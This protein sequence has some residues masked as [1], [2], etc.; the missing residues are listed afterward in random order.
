MGSPDLCLRPPSG[1]GLKKAAVM[2]AVRKKMQSMKFDI[3]ALYQKNAEYEDDIKSS[4]A[5]SD[6]Y[7]VQ[8]RDVGKKVQKLETAFEEIQEK[9][10]ASAAKMDEAEKEFKDKD[11]DVN[12]AARRV[13]LMEGEAT[14]SV[15]KLATTVMKLAL[16]SKE[17]DN[18]IKGARHWESKTMNNNLK[19][20]RRIASDNE[21]KYDNLARSLAM[22]E[23]ELKR[24][25][26]R[27]KLAEGRVVKI[28]EELSTIGDN[29]KQ[30]EISEE[31]ARRRE[32]KYQDQIKQINIKL[33]ESDSRSEYAEMNITKL[34]LR[35]DEL[36]DEIIRE[37]LKINA[38]SG[39]L[40]ATF[41]EMLNKY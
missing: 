27:V 40:D 33:K 35:I 20:A 21:M 34:H 37:K 26:E 8:I 30:L 15:E 10:T 39:Q 32:E 4:N 14:V 19:E 18:I 3:D 31:K 17:A 1:P 25:E 6:E 22:M 41:N 29:Q 24:A 38:V 16:M 2:D 11:D 23:D 7:D 36:E 28:E 12:A 13:V 9:M 5:I